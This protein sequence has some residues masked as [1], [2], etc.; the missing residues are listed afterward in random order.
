MILDPHS[1]LCT[2]LPLY[3]M[4]T[5]ITPPHHHH[6]LHLHH[7]GSD[8][9]R[10]QVATEPGRAW[11]VLYLLLGVAPLPA[12][13]K[14][15]DKTHPAARGPARSAQ[16]RRTQRRHTVGMERTEVTVLQLLEPGAAVFV[17]VRLS[18][19]RWRRCVHHHHP[20]SPSSQWLSHLK[21]AAKE[22]LS[23]GLH[24]PSAPRVE[25]KKKRTGESCSKAKGLIIRMD[26]NNKLYY[27]F[28]LVTNFK[29]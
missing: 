18:L 23:A 6:H 26:C 10:W 13:P 5:V 17:C 12:L 9:E 11:I 19:L 2:V 25:K 14:G 24:G 4:I 28:I 20:H 22:L 21:W 29:P 8:Y 3:Y 16:S 15:G 7:C 1:V 27:K